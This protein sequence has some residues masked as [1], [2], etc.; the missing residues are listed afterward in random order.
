MFIPI[1]GVPLTDDR[2]R[3]FA[4]MLRAS[5]RQADLTLDQ[6]A[7]EAE[8]NVRQFARQINGEEGSI[9]SL[10]RQPDTF[11]RWLGVEIASEFGIPQLARRAMLLRRVTVD[12]RRQLRLSARRERQAS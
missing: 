6:G 3:R 7:Q 8:R 2:R 1:C 5:L 10:M 9:P 4:K 11:W 12:R